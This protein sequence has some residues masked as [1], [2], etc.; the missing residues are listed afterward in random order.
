MLRLVSQRYFAGEIILMNSG[1]AGGMHWRWLGPGLIVLAGI[2]LHLPALQWGFFADDYGHQ[3]IL[4][5]AVEHPTLRPWNLYDFGEFPDRS[6]SMWALGGFPWW[7]SPDWKIRF[8]RPVSSV[9]LCL[10][11]AVWGDWAVGYHLT[12]LALFG[13]YLGLAYA[14][15][16]RMAANRGASLVALAI[17]AAHSS[18]LFSVSWPANRNSLTAQVFVVASLLAVVRRGG[19]TGVVR[20]WFAAWGLAALAALSK[21]S[22]VV[23]FLLLALLGQWGPRRREQPGRAT[24]E[25][26]A[27][28]LAV[29][30]RP[31]LAAVSLCLTGAFVI[32]LAAGGF[33]ARGLFYA[34]PWLEPELFGTRVFVLLAAAPLNLMGVFS[35]DLFL[36]RPRALLMVAPLCL[37]LSGLV[38]RRVWRVVVGHP[39][40]AFLASWFVLAVLPQG[41][42]P[43]SDRLLFE[44]NLPGSLLLGMF[45]QS[46]LAWGQVGADERRYRVRAGRAATVA[47][48]VIVA[49]AIP[50]QAL[51]KVALGRLMAR[52]ANGCREAVVTA[53]VGAP[54][55]GRREAFVLNAPNTLVLLNVLSTWAIETGDRN[56]RFWPMQ[57]GRRG[58]E[59][60]RIDERTFELESRDEPFLTGLLE[61]VFLTSKAPPAMGTRWVTAL[62]GVEA[63]KSDEQGLRA[64]RVTCPESLDS[65]H[66]RFLISQGNRWIRAMPPAVGSSL[67]IDPVHTEHRLIP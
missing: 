6:G 40:G 33:G 56:V 12:G 10:D 38:A 1:T 9:S 26:E 57:Y 54:E 65:E 39:F 51:T 2:A 5:S 44:V 7:T 17:G 18:A 46:I 52:V 60:R 42:A 8:F 11:H 13:V 58:L 25:T 21:E 36:E 22:G 48:W 61:G 35:T 34:T 3:V 41:G 20:H 64:F 63:T 4:R 47:A 43:T 28:D 37:V 66:Y 16:T 15:F 31:V 45:L 27:V 50:G 62:C 14:L 32:A 19:V 53:D 55:S 30:N 67:R 24:K 23:A 49:L 29:A 59:W